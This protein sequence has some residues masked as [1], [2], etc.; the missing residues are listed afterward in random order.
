MRRI[1]LFALGLFGGLIG[2]ALAA[3]VLI[4]SRGDETSNELALVAIADGL[5]LRSHAAAFR[6][7]SLATW[8]AGV[9]LDLSGVQLAPDGAHLELSTLMSGV[10]IRLPAGCRIKVEQ[11]GAA[12]GFTLQLDG[13]EDLPPDAPTLT[14]RALVVGSGV[15]VTN[16]ADDDD[17]D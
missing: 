5:T 17:L 14:L 10:S 15:A 9:D 11:R 1:L 2:S 12:Q 6:G 4:P 7:G 13:Q 3:R 16:R 8:F